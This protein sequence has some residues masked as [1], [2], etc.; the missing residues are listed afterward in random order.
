MPIPDYQT[1]M[2]PLLKALARGGG[3]ERRLKDLALLLAEAFGLTEEERNILLPSGQP[4]FL[5]RLSWARTYLKKA[6]LL[7]SPRPGWVRITP[8]GLEVLKEN[9]KRIDN[10]FLMRFEGFRAFLEESRRPRAQRAHGWPEE[11]AAIPSPEETLDRAYAA[12]KEEVLEDLLERVKGASP[13]FFERL[14]VRLLVEMGYGG[15]F[16]EAAQ[17]IGRS[18]DGGIDGVIKEDRLGLEAIYIQAKR[19]DRP[20]GRPEVQSFVG[21]LQ[22]HRAR[23]GVFL[24]TSTFTR[25]AREYVERVDGRIVLVD[26]KGLAE[27]MFEYGVG[28]STT[29]AY[30]VKRVDSDF[31]LEDW[32][33]SRSRESTPNQGGKGPNEKGG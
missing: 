7:E 16:P 21:A 15:S 19:W 12:L 2:L 5:N 14:V 26:G 18:G 10:A 11:Q 17:A 25:E 3:E 29:V 13:A 32:E 23:K 4:L 6:G 22:V 33:I 24:T 9:P 31:F 8:L 30:Y 1:L 20:V 27:L 28:V